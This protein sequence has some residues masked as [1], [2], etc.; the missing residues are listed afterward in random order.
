MTRISSSILDGLSPEKRA[1]FLEKLRQKG[2]LAAAQG[3]EEWRPIPRRADT[4]AY[5]LSFAQQRLW[6]LSQL[7]PDSPFYNI[8]LALR[9]SGPLDVAALERALNEIVGRHDVL[10]ASFITERGNPVQVIAPEL[11]LSLQ[12]E[13]LAPASSGAS[14]AAGVEA[15]ARSIAAAEA[16]RPFDLMRGPLVRSRLL[17]LAGDEFLALLTFHHI[18][19]DGWSTG[20]F[21]SE[22]GALY[23]AYAGPGK[24]GVP[25]PLAPLQIQY[26]D[27]AAWQRGQLQGERL[28]AELAYWKEQ[29]HGIPPTLELPTDRPRPAVQTV[30]GAVYPFELPAHLVDRLRT[31]AHNDT[32]TGGG[33]ATLYQVLLGAFQ[34]LLH[35]YSNQD[36]ICVG[37]P[38]ANR[39]RQEI[40]GLIG[41][42]VN[43]LVMRSRFEDKPS[44]HALLR[45]LK[46]Q[47]LAAQSHQDVP[48]EMLVDE[49]SAAGEAAAQRNMAVTPVFQVMFTLEQNSG[50]DGR[51]AAPLVG[52]TINPVATH[53][54]T[55]KFDL[56]LFVSENANGTLTG[57]FEYNTDLWYTS[58]IGRIAGHY[59]KLLEGIVA[60]P[61]T[62]VDLLPILTAAE[63]R[64][65]ILEWNDTATDYPRDRCLH[66]LFEEQVGLRPNAPAVTYGANTLSYA[67]LNARANRLAHWLQEL[68]VGPEVL[69]GVY[70][71]RGIDMIVAILGIIKAGGAYL[72]LD[73][74]YPADR[75]AFMLADGNVPVLITQ[76]MLRDRAVKLVVER[77]ELV[78]IQM[79]ADAPQ[80]ASRSTMPPPVTVK[81]ANLAY[82]I[83]TSGSTGIPKGV[84]IQQRA[85]ARLIFNTN[86]IDLQPGDKIGQ[87]SNASFDAATFEIWG[88]LLRGGE[89]IGVDKETA[90]SPGALA[91][92]LRRSGIGIMFLTAALFNYVASEEPTA[93]N[94]MSCLMAGGEA[95]D[96]RWVRRVLE[97]GGPARLLNGY[98]PT[99]STTFATWHPIS[100]VPPD[101]LGV[102]IGRPLSN[103][104]VYVLDRHFRPVPI[105]VSGELCIGGDGLA[106]GY[107]N[108]PEL[109]AEKFV[110]NPFDGHDAPR[111][112][113]TGDLVR[114][115]PNGSIEFQGRI[116]HQVKIR[117]FRIELGEIETMLGRHPQVR[118]A[119]AMVSPGNLV[120]DASGAG[121]DTISST[122]RK[123][124][125]CI[126]PKEGAAAPSTSDL[127]SHLKQHLPDYMI[128]AAF[129]LLDELPI[130][131]NG[132]VDRGALQRIALQALSSG[133]AESERAYVAPRSPVERFL[134]EKWQ[135]VLGV[136]K[137]SVT[138]NF[139]ELGGNSLQAA[140][141]T[142]RMQE[143]LGASAHVRAL[144]MAPTIADLA[145]YLD[146][147]YPDAVARIAGIGVVPA[148]KREPSGPGTGGASAEGVG[149]AGA[150]ASPAAY[151]F[152]EKVRAAQVDDAKVAQFGQIVPP[153]PARGE[154]PLEMT[155]RNPPAVFVLSPP[156]SGST[157]LRVM[158]AGN[159]QLFAPPELD[160][161]SFNTLAERRDAFSGKFQFWLEGPLKAI[162]EL[163]QCSADEA[164][165]IMASFERAGWSTKRFYRQLQEWIA[166]SQRAANSGLPVSQ[167]ML[168]DKTPVYPM[169]RHI[170]ARMEQDFENARYIHL[171]RHPFATVYSFMEAKLE[172]I[173]FRWDHPWSMREL[174][175]LVYLVSHR[176]ILNFLEQIPAE[177]QHR[178]W[179]EEMVGDAPRVMRGI[180]DFL[181][182]E[183]HPDMLEPYKGDKMTS[184]IRPGHQMVG[185]FKFYLRNK[186]D[187]KAADRWKR[188]KKDDRL[189]EQT[190]DVARRLN[191]ELPADEEGGESAA[192]STNGTGHNQNGA[193]NAPIRRRGADEP[194]VLSFAQERLWFLDQFEGAGANGGGSPFYNVPAAV[195]LTGNIDVG[196][197]RWAL[198]TIVQRHEVLRTTFAS[199][200]GVASPVVAEHLEVEL[201]VVDLA[202]LP[203]EMRE[204]EAG[205]LAAEEAR[206][207]FNLATGPLL[208]ATL[209]DLGTSEN[210]RETVALITMHHIVSDGW[211]VNVFIREL[212][213]LYGAHTS[214][215]RPGQPENTA[216]LLPLP[217]QY[218][219]FAAWQRNWFAG[220]DDAHAGGSRRSPLQDQLDY[221]IEQL[222][223]LPARLD[224]PTDRPRPAVQTLNG[225]R[226][227]FTL[228]EELTGRIKAL[229]RSE[230]VTLFMTLL[231][232]FQTLLMRY[233]GEEDLAVGTPIAG[234]N[235]PEMANLIGFFVNTLV[236]RGDLS[237]AP[238]EA[239]LTFRQL[240]KRTQ[241]TAIKAFANQDVPFETLV[242]TLQ[243]QG[244]QPQRDMSHTPLF[245]VM[246]ALQDAPLQAMHA[247]GLT[248][249]PL[250]PD[251]KTAKFDLMLNVVER[252][253]V[254]RCALEYNTDLFRASTAVRMAQHLQVLLQ[255]I[256][257]DLPRQGPDTPLATLP[258]LTPAERQMMLAD[259]NDTRTD[260]D[261][262]D[263]LAARFEAQARKTPEAQAVIAEVEQGGAGH[264]TSLTYAELD[265]RAGALAKHLASL[266]VGPE[267]IVGLMADRSLDLLVGVVGIWKAGA[268]YVPLD[269]AYPPDR[270]AYMLSDS[271]ARV[272][273]TQAQHARPEV[274]DD[275]AVVLL[276]SDALGVA[277]STSAET[278][279]RHAAPDN[280]AYVIYTSG[281][282]GRPKGVSVTHRTALNLAAALQR[283]AYAEH[284]DE[285]PL[286]LSLNAPLS[287]DASVQQLVMLTLGHTL[288]VVP[289][290]VRADAPALLAFIR[291]Q[292]L[293]QL[294][295][296]PSQLKLL[297]E[298]G[299]LA[300]DAEWRPSIVFPG[301]E[302]IDEPTWAT[303]AAA[304]ETRFYNMYGPTECTVDSTT[305]SAH[306]APRRPTIGR[307]LANVRAYVLD[308]NLEPA[309]IGVPGELYLAGAGVS[310]GYLHRPDLTAE[311][312]LP[313]PFDAQETP[314]FGAGRMY[315]TGDRVRWLPDG[316]L[317]FLGRVDFQ[318]KVR[319]FRIELGEIEEALR[320]HPGLAEA[321]VLV[322][323]DAGPADEGMSGTKR[324]V[325]YVVPRTGSAAATPLSTA[326][327]RRHLLTSLPEYMLPSAFMLLDAMPLTPNGK[328]DR[329]ALLKL[330]PDE[331]VRT[332][333]G[334]S[335][336][337]PSGFVQT[338]LAEIYGRVLGLE[339]VGI[340]DNFFE[341]GGDSILTIQAVAHAGQAGITITPK[342]IFQAPTVSQLA[343]L[344]E[345]SAAAGEAGVMADEQG[346]VEGDLPL[347]PI[348]HRFFETGF[349]QPHHWNQSLLLAVQ[350]QIDPKSMRDAVAAV[351]GQHDA[352]R[353]RFAV[354]DGQWRQ[355]NAGLSDDVPFE[356]IDLSALDEPARG[357]ALRE[358]T[359]RLQQSLNV[360]HGPLLRVAYFDFGPNAAGRLLTIVHHLAVDRVSW[361]LILEDLGSAYEQAC[362]G[363]APQLPRK[364]TA[365]RDWARRLAE[366]AGSSGVAAEAKR[367][368]QWGGQALPAA[369]AAPVPCDYPAGSNLEADA[370]T[371]AVY[372]NEAETG[373]L[374]QEAGKAYG[375]EVSDA[376]LTALGHG[377][378]PLDGLARVPGGSRR[379][380]P[381][382]GTRRRI[383][384]KRRREQNQP[385]AHGRLVYIR[386][387]GPAAD[388]AAR[389]ARPGVDGRQGA[390]PRHAERW[391]RLRGAPLPVH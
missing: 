235:R 360:S 367:W 294:D 214:E 318:V 32:A 237:S 167:R 208:R 70:L 27:F 250:Q 383:A 210:G 12:P 345:A 11:R 13:E 227:T 310:R 89:L 165:S 353:L 320:S 155:D 287:F 252:T 22:L 102:P 170:L 77:P 69:V 243:R 354:V 347:T 48:F 42:F 9:L 277:G 388:S 336:V 375:T 268:A 23:A 370:R 343:L 261:T 298:E 183:F 132:K 97:H 238:G 153:L 301:G 157:L 274:V 230:G 225:E 212:A 213:A 61:D 158:L 191:Y 224:L 5:P 257:S 75:L 313:D 193:Q 129:V 177:R 369:E 130:N 271:G 143:E 72:P 172:D 312:F 233:T 372:L 391:D 365:F 108:R 184:G 57:S 10:R 196:A 229:A 21:V 14:A 47:A 120:Q 258:V 381:P 151:T 285:R 189:A 133:P 262:G 211:S 323:E 328:L 264:S 319:G 272:L 340:N 270:L 171:V 254:L 173:F 71:E 152:Q 100:E 90:L 240:L 4:A 245:Q 231:A 253:D 166:E 119:F 297:L 195:R 49:L 147:Y 362:S 322:A 175:E 137:V 342:Q 55:A 92:Y 305:I 295:C 379:P 123:I 325:A 113:R 93:F 79:D 341:L 200:N 306:V 44:F 40:E 219:D 351:L 386:I 348:Q 356:S 121:A 205:R 114:W 73:M 85:I 363:R 337:E 307:P 203:Q 106:V 53:S 60:Q 142:N 249:S 292:R 276:D 160:L 125:A 86:Y 26:A 334:T 244:A 206:R 38:V 288:V 218:A 36:D 266:G 278:S 150:S 134:A 346:P 228:P 290:D 248:L 185:D 332:E 364:T 80:L 283:A 176:N 99:E 260:V 215:A 289:Q 122:E 2:Q 226:Y 1:L 366:Y 109:T 198:N 31:L 101:A 188:F 324:L 3:A 349:A 246:F 389:R 8:P 29:L 124:V 335:Y 265:A 81:P 33:A 182:I 50:G 241:A 127:R 18:V 284:G 104:Q 96:P 63:V 64:Q 314:G 315:R 236:M 344:A 115:L 384:R 45:R 68:G 247:P 58:T 293:D 387:P 373:T 116:D 368:M 103:T 169:D 112:Y 98:G 84:S 311:R 136:E 7:E 255:S 194:P 273:V 35:R 95:L 164:E 281:S 199:V 321:V 91:A 41:F 88:S 110:P 87:I 242:D 192:G 46:E 141:L 66:E 181:Q 54:G 201:S 6:I 78:L 126:M 105:G 135:E 149:T 263:T 355:W 223:G 83:Y 385:R 15:A 202:S 330:S 296:V 239:P 43:T 186:I 140:V 207:P 333:T 377:L 180:C 350:A 146:E 144:F 154:S 131:P 338:T 107:L 303:L 34:V 282:T 59:L 178:V 82:V 300:E 17:K 209:L 371:V 361:R 187:P 304:P 329:K 174:A 37:T 197:L 326:D 308:R 25:S 286:R 162:M 139:F 118:Q 163:R 317:E 357:E 190:W 168:V 380:R 28:S 30:N 299:L 316:T 280:L 267:S 217:I 222:K 148:A 327:L 339:R 161:M 279:G 251:T 16:R 67:D 358:H 145:N 204:V 390:T 220:H 232:A 302:A 24:D 259:W 138:D 159:P 20:V 382:G 374:I 56:T 275:L 19:M 331:A 221:W 234:R 51:A 256:V 62:S 216:V 94:T 128:P 52:I 291:R 156:R 111:L 65:V 117:G 309:P 179:F 76:S 39:N 376:L 352:L 359:L 378:P 74:E 269:P